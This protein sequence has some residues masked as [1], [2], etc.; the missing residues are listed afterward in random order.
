[1]HSFQI[2]CHIF[3]SLF[4]TSGGFPGGSMI[5]NA[6]AN[7]RKDTSSIPGSGRSGGEDN[8]HQSSCLKYSKD[9]GAKGLQKV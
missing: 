8:P 1:M 6:P 5:K 4:R 9:R 3:N 2:T 7:A